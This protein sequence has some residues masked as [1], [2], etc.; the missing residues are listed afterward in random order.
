MGTFAG[1]QSGAY[2]AMFA[3]QKAAS[4]AQSIIS[5]QTGIAMAAANPF[6]LNLAAMASVAAATASIVGNIQSVGLNLATGGYVRG[7]GTGTS[8]SIPANLSNGEF[9]VNASATKRNRAL[10]EAINSNERVSVAGGA[11]SVAVAQPGGQGAQA[12]QVVHEVTIENYSRS[13]IETRTDPDGRL[14]V[15]VQAVKDEIA[16]EIATG[17]GTVVDAGE[18]AYGWKRNA[19]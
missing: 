19:I 9:V 17:Y 10:L 1:Q 8:D 4:I 5:I 7:P 15:L 2:K 13:Q 11:G 6:P 16:D 18:A 12:A 14:R 3:V